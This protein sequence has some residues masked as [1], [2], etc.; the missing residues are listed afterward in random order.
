MSKHNPHHL[1]QVARTATHVQADRARPP[2]PVG[3]DKL[4]DAETLIHVSHTER[5]DASA[6]AGDYGTKVQYVDEVLAAAGKDR[7][8][9]WSA[10]GRKRHRGSQEWADLVRDYT[11]GDPPLLLADRYGIGQAAIAR[12]LAADPS[13]TVR[14]RQEA[15]ALRSAQIAEA[16]QIR[17]RLRTGTLDAAAADLGI[18]SATLRAVLESHGLLPR[19]VTPDH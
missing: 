14:D 9:L 16:D 13:V 19:D 7:S 12:N 17:Y 6:L 18:D 1:R 11:A 10:P 8:A 3:V 5:L 15:G 2:A 4:P